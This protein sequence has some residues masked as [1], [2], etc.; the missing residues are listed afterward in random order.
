M[1]FLKIL[2]KI[3]HNFDEEINMK[4]GL[5][6]SYNHSL[7]IT[8]QNY[9]LLQTVGQSEHEKEPLGG[10]VSPLIIAVIRDVVE[11]CPER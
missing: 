9:S 3:I 7:L 1:F 6:N 11:F 10:I 5:V 8:A 2:L 4:K